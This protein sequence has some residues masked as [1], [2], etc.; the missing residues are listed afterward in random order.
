MVFDNFKI[1]SFL[2]SNNNDNSDSYLDNTNNKLYVIPTYKSNNSNLIIYNISNSDLANNNFLITI[3]CN[4]PLYT[5]SSIKEYFFIKDKEFNEEYSSNMN[6][7]LYTKDLA[8][9][10]KINKIN[11]SYTIVTRTVTS[12]NYI[13]GFYY[14][15]INNN[16]TYLIH[17]TGKHIFNI[18]LS[19]RYELITNIPNFLT[20]KANNVIHLKISDFIYIIV[21]DQNCIIKWNIKDLTSTI[22]LLENYNIV[23]KKF[24]KAIYSYITQKIYLIPYNITELISIDFTNKIEF[25]KL[26]GLTKIRKKAFFSTAIEYQGYIYM[27]PESYNYIY[28]FDIYNNKIINIIDISSF[29]NVLN[30]SRKFINAHLF[31]DS[32][33]KK[34]FAIP[35][36]YN[37]LGIIDYDQGEGTTLD[38]DINFNI[39]YSS[40]FNTNTNSVYTLINPVDLGPNTIYNTSYTRGN[41]LFSLYTQDSSTLYEWKPKSAISILNTNTFSLYTS[42]N[43]YFKDS[44]DKIIF[45]IYNPPTNTFNYKKIELSDFI[46]PTNNYKINNLAV[47]N[48]YS[49]QNNTIYS[50]PYNFKY[51]LELDLNVTPPLLKINDITKNKDVNANL[52]TVFMN[53]TINGRFNCSIIVNNKLYIVPYIDS[54][55]SAISITLYPF[56]IYDFIA[57]NIVIKDLK[58]FITGAISPT[59]G[60]KL[61]CAILFYNISTTQYLF[62]IKKNA[63]FCLSYNINNSE[64]KTITFTNEVSSQNYVDGYI[65]NNILYLLTDNYIISYSINISASNNI[66]FIYVSKSILISGITDRYSKIL[67]ND[68]ILYCIPYNDNKLGIFDTISYTL[69]RIPIEYSSYSEN[70]NLFKGGTL[71]VLNQK[72]YIIMVPY[73]AQ[74][75][76]IY[77][78]TNNIFSY[79]E[80]PIFKTNKFVNCAVDIKGNIYMNTAEGNILYYVLSIEKN[81]LKPRLPV[82]SKETISFKDIYKKFHTDYIYDTYNFNNRAIKISDYLN[83]G[84]AEYFTVAAIKDNKFI[85]DNTNLI[86]PKANSNTQINTT[87][88]D[89]LPLQC[90]IIVKLNN[91]KKIKSQRYEYYDIAG[92]GYIIDS[93]NISYNN[94]YLHYVKRFP[95]NITLYS[96]NT[97]INTNIIT[98]I[99]PLI[100]EN[101]PN[102][103]PLLIFSINL[104]NNTIIEK[105][106]STTDQLNIITNLNIFINRKKNTDLTTSSRVD[107]NSLYFILNSILPGSVRPIQTM[108]SLS[109]INFDINGALNSGVNIVITKS[110][111]GYLNMLRIINIKISTTGIINLINTDIAIKNLIILKDTHK[112][113]GN[114]IVN[115]HEEIITPLELYNSDELSFISNANIIVSSKKITKLT[116][117]ITV[118]RNISI[119]INKYNDLIY[120]KN[121]VILINIPFTSI[122]TFSG[123]EIRHKLNII[124]YNNNV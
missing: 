5:S 23:I 123:S 53:Q 92:D 3:A 20:T 41:T 6:I 22:I 11:H 17:E 84:G 34:I 124:I 98:D 94:T 86:I 110:N 9:N 27:I 88:L 10:L 32:I 30:E 81:Y 76:Y 25:I 56:V 35:N 62:L 44:S 75:L 80:D 46:Y 26:K 60:A 16:N 40:L 117:C 15:N 71:I 93:V 48:I 99:N 118:N 7:E 58:N 31:K 36:K 104:E 54:Y 18:T 115:I 87:Y 105:M 102:I 4:I 82:L 29:T 70:A 90:N 95:T 1:G 13:D 14:Y 57:N 42:D 112:F 12:D 122:I 21:S 50:I 116:I 113:S 55:N 114:L 51:L 79:I 2:N 121:I 74:K 63:A 59:S 47:N 28:I 43:T 85:I 106:T 45:T 38:I 111:N 77:N 120:L 64:F 66:S 72:T 33:R 89:F 69:T 49:I 65:N 39:I 78:I 108:S 19:T 107:F 101:I 96:L 83:Q 8:L 109:T 24:S 103:L 68:N 97:Q 119:D 91:Y 37:N 61:F 73:N 52:F 67:F 100:I